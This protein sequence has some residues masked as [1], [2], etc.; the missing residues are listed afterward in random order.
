MKWRFLFL[1]STF[2]L[3]S[4][5]LFSQ[6]APSIQWQK[7]LGGSGDDSGYSYTIT[8]DGGY[9]LAGYSNSNDGDVSGNHGN[10][11]AW[12]VKLDHGG[13]VVWKKCFGGSKKDQAFDIIQTSD[14]NYVFDGASSSQ[15]G[16]VSTNKGGLDYWI[17]K[18]D[19][20]A[21]IIWER[22]LGGTLDETAGNIQQTSDGGFVMIG[23]TISDNGDVSGL[24]DSTDYWLTRLDS[25]G[26]I[27]W[28][29]CLGGSSGDYGTSVRQL[30]DGGYIVAGRSASNDGD[31]SGNHGGV[32]CWIARLDSSG[33]ILWQKCYG[34][35]QNEED[36]YAIPALNGGFIVGAITRST[37]GNVTATNKGFDDYWV[38]RMNSSGNIMWQQTYGGCCDDDDHYITSTADHCYL[39][40]GHTYSDDQEVSG[41]HGYAADYWLIKIDTFGNLLWQKCMGGSDGTYGDRGFKAEQTSD[42]GYVMFGRSDATDGDVAGGNHGGFDYWIVKLSPDVVSNSITTSTIFPLSYMAGDHVN[43]PFTITGTFT[44]GNIFSSQLSDASG[45]FSNPVT[46]GSLSS[47]NSGTISSTIPANIIAGNGYRIR[48]VSSNPSVTGTDNGENISISAG[49]NCM[50]PTGFSTT[51]ITSTSAQL[52]W[53]AVNGI[54]SYKVRYRLANIN[55]WT[56]VNSGTNSKMIH[57]L[58]PNSKYYWEVRSVCQTHPMINSAWSPKTKFTTSAQKLS[59]NEDFHFECFPN[60]ASTSV[61]IRFQLQEEENISLDLFS[62]TGEKVTT[63][64]NGN[65][66]EGLH[67]L[68]INVR[69]LAKGIYLLNFKSASGF[70]I[71]KLVIQ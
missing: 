19:T 30:S 38:I 36:A 9:L 57:S 45:S 61:N 2:T 27:V 41:N 8:S 50:V 3:I 70:Q 13:N 15:N 43:V 69:D 52:N 1:A 21:N 11:D 23:F 68:E 63:L 56:T 42:G 29:K 24:H 7:S 22:T 35:S 71:Q 62:L 25:H 34:G 10:Y 46:I 20:N 47:V 58:S 16:D 14:G 4:S 17:V 5:I 53:N 67:Q 33:S 48:V 60:P 54:I 6:S 18:I 49:T 32:D 12:I 39:L 59:E 65:L 37:D 66:D 31:V 26:F 28:Q 55:T 51:N 40:A 64:I 44:G